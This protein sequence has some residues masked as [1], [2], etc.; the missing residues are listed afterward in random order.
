MANDGTQRFA[1]HEWRAGF[2]PLLNG[3]EGIDSAY[4]DDVAAV[5]RALEQWNLHAALRATWPDD[6]AGALARYQIPLPVETL[7]PLFDAEQG[8]R[9]R[10]AVLNGEDLVDLPLALRRY[11]AFMRELLRW[12]DHYRQAC[13]PAHPLMR[14]WWHRQVARIRS[15]LGPT[16]AD[17][18]V[19]APV[20]FELSSGCSVGCW[21]CAL[22]APTL[23]AVWPYTPAHRQQW[24]AILRV[25]HEVI[26]PAAAQGF[27]YWATEPFDNPDYERFLLDFHAVLG[28]FPMTTTALPMRDPTRTHALIEQHRRL[29]PGLDRFSVL[30]T[31]IA[32]RIHAEFSPRQLL[33]TELLPQNK[34]ANPKFR[35]ARAGRALTAKNGPDQ[36]NQFSKTPTTIAC[37]SGFLI[38]PCERRVQLMTPCPVSASSPEGFQ[39]LATGQF[40][41][42]EAL[43]DLLESMIASQMP[44][45]LPWQAEVR[46][47]SDL[48]VSSPRANQLRFKSPFTSLSFGAVTGAAQFA[49]LL[50]KGA[51][52][53]AQIAEAREQAL[54]VPPEQSFFLI[55][56]FRQHGLLDETVFA[57][58]SSAHRDSDGPCHESMGG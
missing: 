6:P 39:V 45:D 12:R 16:K 31:G 7:T 3:L 14:A 54:D 52:T 33:L 23:Q 5:K 2:V 15:Q 17:A 42:A 50:S 13:E 19:H 25:A 35:K 43:R 48:V 53:A 57:R 49:T 27:C 9:L 55:D 40:S 34:G 32:S 1:E 28:R 24:Q 26:G 56:H 44:M 8:D 30:S 18:I 22:S 37:V 4:L 11:L 29:D 41:S 36:L 58:S 20:A 46:L 21:F 47:R 38:N 51:M 10:Q